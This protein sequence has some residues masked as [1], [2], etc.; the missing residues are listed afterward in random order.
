[1]IQKTTTTPMIRALVCIRD[2]FVRDAQFY[3]GSNLDD[4]HDEAENDNWV[5][6]EGSITVFIGEAVSL[7]AAIVDIAEFYDCPPEIFEGYRIAKEGK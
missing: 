3:G 7:E 1:M 4:P 2:S 5:D 6:T